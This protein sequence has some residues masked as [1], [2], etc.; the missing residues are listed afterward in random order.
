MVVRDKDFLI[1]KNYERDT[2]TLLKRWLEN[3][4]AGVKFDDYL[5]EFHYKRI[6]I[7]DAGEI[8]RILYDE[9]KGTEIEVVCFYDRNAE[10]LRQIEGIPVCSFTQLSEMPDADIVIV[11]TAY[12]YSHILELLV[13][14]DN[15]IRTVY[16][17]DAVYEF[18]DRKEEE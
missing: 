16:L 6:I 11:S 5:K 8:G 15:K 17:R 13:E 7:F 14:V 2:I 9:L 18:P 1:N 12:D 4:N 3:R 10:G